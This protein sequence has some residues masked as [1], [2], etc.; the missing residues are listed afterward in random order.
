MD[1]EKFTKCFVD[2]SCLLC[3]PC[4]WHLGRAAADG[5]EFSGCHGP[6]L[7][8]FALSNTLELSDIDIFCFLFFQL[9]CSGSEQMALEPLVAFRR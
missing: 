5:C 9:V 6:G 1:S 3:K 7:L 2:M 4:K 8:G